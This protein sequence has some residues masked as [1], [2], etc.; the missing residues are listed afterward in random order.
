MAYQGDGRWY[1]LMREVVLLIEGVRDGLIV[2]GSVEMFY[3]G[4][5]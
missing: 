4:V 3:D 5:D 2:G 1:L